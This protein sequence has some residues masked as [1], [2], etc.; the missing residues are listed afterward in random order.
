MIP[1]AKPKI[2]LDEVV[3][4]YASKTLLAT[5]R[6]FLLGIRGY[7]S[8]TMGPTSGNDRRI[9]DDAMVIISPTVF[10]TF[11]AN[12]DPNGYGWS[13]QTKK[14]L[15]TIQ[16][17]IYMYQVGMHKAGKPGAHM[18]LRQAGEVVIVR[19]NGKREQG[20][21]GINIHKGGVTSTSSAGCVTVPPHQW[22][23]FFK[24]VR[25]QMVEYKISMIPFQ[26]VDA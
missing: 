13:D 5:N 24:E 15:P 10:R 2:R 16:P 8:K 11:N 25:T 1:P 4:K 14:Y 23:D 22:E 9:Y 21:F 18:A 19:D 26:V 6:P 17:G 3:G 12:L 7:Y 20:F